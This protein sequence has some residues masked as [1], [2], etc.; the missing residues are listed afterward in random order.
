MVPM[1][2]K[3]FNIPIWNAINAFIHYFSLKKNHFSLKRNEIVNKSINGIPYPPDCCKII[4]KLLLQEYNGASVNGRKN[5]FFPLFHWKTTK[6]VFLCSFGKN[7]EVFLLNFCRFPDKQRK[8]YLRF[9]PAFHTCTI[10]QKRWRDDVNYHLP[11]Y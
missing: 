10:V 4:F 6:K 5:N 3:P 11:T 2:F 8:K 9:Y 1:Y 7:S